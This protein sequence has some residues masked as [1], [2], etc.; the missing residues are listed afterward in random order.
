MGS[1]V[2]FSIVLLSALFL[3]PQPKRCGLVP[4]GYEFLWNARWV[5]ELERGG[6]TYFPDVQTTLD[7]FQ[8]ASQFS[9]SVSS[10]LRFFLD[11]EIDYDPEDLY[12]HATDTSAL[13]GSFGLTNDPNAQ[14][15]YEDKYR[16]SRKRKIWKILSWTLPLLPGY[17]YGTN[18]L[19]KRYDTSSTYNFK[20]KSFR[21]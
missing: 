21:R 15:A 6:R 19:P 11:S 17:D 3:Q 9:N 8:S 1:V 5:E 18:F 20:M 4:K 7:N 10:P 16:K 2:P 14:F 13:G 12:E